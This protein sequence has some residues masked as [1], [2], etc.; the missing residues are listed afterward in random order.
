MNLRYPGKQ[1]VVQ[2]DI[3]SF[4]WVV[5]YHVLRYTSHSVAVDTLQDIMIRIFDDYSFN[6]GVY[7]GGLTKKLL[8]TEGR[9]TVLGKNFKVAD[10]EPLTSF[11]MSTLA[12]LRE[13]HNFIDPLDD[14]VAPRKSPSNK[15][16]SLKES[17]LFLFDQPN[18]PLKKTPSDPPRTTPAP[19]SLENIR[20]RNHDSIAQTWIDALEMEWPTGDKAKDNLPTD[21]S[22]GTTS[23]RPHDDDGATVA[24]APKQKKSKS[25]G[26]RGI[27]MTTR[28]SSTKR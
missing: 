12:A 2:D 10:N 1:H 20:L 24:G 19:L 18:G 9:D 17:A 27:P 4:V 26:S 21:T 15:K 8:C 6:G 11:I 13:W 3:E 16:S 5:L 14:E 25:M 23:K 22:R 28:R 7:D